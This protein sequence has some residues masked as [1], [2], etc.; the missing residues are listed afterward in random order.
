MKCDVEWIS[1]VMR[2]RLF[3]AVL[4]VA[5][6]LLQFAFIKAKIHKVM[7]AIIRPKPSSTTP[8]NIDNIIKVSLRGG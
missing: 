7:A 5:E 6:Y 1:H 4:R 3:V 8:V 2:A